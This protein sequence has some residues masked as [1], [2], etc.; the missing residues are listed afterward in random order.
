MPTSLRKVRRQRGSRTHGWGQVGQHRG[1]GSKGGTGKAGL[2]KHKWS[3][4]VKY[5]PDHFGHDSLKPPNQVRAEK[6][7]NVGQLD[8]L[9]GTQEV[10]KNRKEATINL[11]EMG[12]DKLLGAGSVDNAYVVSV[13]LFTPSAKTKVEKAGGKLVE[14]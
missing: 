14:G 12:Y 3:W 5:A 10:D 7:I 6:W 13:K 8:A 4:T 1:S 2:H 11:V 9:Y